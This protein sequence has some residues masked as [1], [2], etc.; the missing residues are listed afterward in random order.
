[1]TELQSMVGYTASSAVNDGDSW[2]NI[3]DK[4]DPR[5]RVGVEWPWNEPD[6]KTSS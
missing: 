6:D 5:G 3:D 4:D 2:L 1:M